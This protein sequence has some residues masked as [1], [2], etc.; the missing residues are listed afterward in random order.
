MVGLPETSISPTI[1]NTDSFSCHLTECLDLAG[2]IIIDTACQRTCC[3]MKWLKLHDQLL[4][5]R[6]LS[7]KKL[8]VSDH[9]QFGAGGV[10]IAKQ[11]A[12]IPVGLQ[13]TKQQGLLFGAGVLQL[14]LPLLASNTL[15]D[16]LGS[17]INLVEMK[18]HATKLGIDIPIERKHNHLV[19]NILNFPSNVHLNSC[20]QQL[21]DSAVWESPHPEFIAVPGVILDQKSTVQ[22]SIQSSSDANSRTSPTASGMAP[23]LEDD[24]DQVD[25]TANQVPSTDVKDGEIQASTKTVAFADGGLG[26]SSK[27]TRDCSETPDPSKGVH[28]PDSS[29]VRKPIWPVCSVQSMRSEVPVERRSTRLGALSAKV[30]AI[31]CLAAAIFGNHGATSDRGRDSTEDQGQEFGQ[32]FSGILTNFADSS[33]G[34]EAR[35]VHPL[36][37]GGDHP[38]AKCNEPL[39]R[40]GAGEHPRSRSIPTGLGRSGSR[41]LLPIQSPGVRLGHVE[42]QWEFQDGMLVRHHRMPRTTLFLPDR[43]QCPIQI[44]RLLPICNAKMWFENSAHQQLQYNW[45]ELQETNYEETMPPWT[46]CTVFKISKT[47][48][49]SGSNYATRRKLRGRLLQT[50]HVFAAEASIMETRTP[51]LRT[52]VDI[53]ETFAGQGNI[54]RRCVQFGLKSLAPIDYE[55]GWDLYRKE[56]QRHVDRAL[57]QFKPLLLVQGLDCK[58][59]CLLQDNVNYIHRLE[60]LWQRRARARPLVKRAAGWCAKQSRENRYW[61]IENPLTSRLWQEEC[62][63]QI[64]Q[65]PNVETAVCHGGAYGMTNSKHQLVKKSFRFMGNCEPILRRLRKKLD[66]ELLKQCVPIEGSETTATQV[67]PPEMVK[68]IILGARELAKQHDPDR[69]VPQRFVSYAVEVDRSDQTWRPIL[70]EAMDVFGL[71]NQ[72]T[73]VLTRGDKLAGTIM[74]MIPS[75][76]IERIQLSLQPLTHRFLTHIPHTHR[77]WVLWFNDDS[78]DVGLEDLG[79]LRYPRSRFIKPVRLA[80]FVFGFARDEQQTGAAGHDQE[81]Q[82][83]ELP[84]DPALLQGRATSDGMSFPGLEKI[85]SEIKRAVKRL[86][87]NMG[88]PH[89]SEL[90]KLLSLNGVRNQAIFTAID[91]LHCDSCARTK[92]LPRPNPAGIPSNQGFMQFGDVVQMDIFYTR[93]LTGKNYTVLGCICESTHLHQAG[94]IPDRTPQSVLECLDTMWFKPY[95]YPLQIKTDCDGAFQGAFID[96]A[97]ENG[98]H[99]DYASPENHAEIGLVERHNSTLRSI[100]ERIVDCRGVTDDFNMKIAI[101]AALFGKNAC[102][103]TH[104]RPPFIAALGRIPRFGTDLLSDP[105]A[106]V[107]GSTAAEAQRTADLM[108]AEAQKQIAVMAID[109]SVRRALLKKTEAQ[110]ALDVEPGGIVAYWRWTARSHK[111]RGGFKLGRLLGRDPD[112]KSIWVQSGGSSIKVA[113]HQ[114]RQALGF[115]QWMP[116]KEDLQSL[117]DAATNLQQGEVKDHSLPAPPQNLEPIFSG[118]ELAAANDPYLPLVVPTDLEEASRG[119]KR[120]EPDSSPQPEPSLPPQINQQQQ[121]QIQQNIN[122]EVQSP[123]HRTINIQQSNFGIPETL[124]PVRTPL[125]RTRSRTPSRSTGRPALEPVPEL[126]DALPEV[127]LTPE[128]SDGNAQHAEETAL[129]SNVEQPLQQDSGSLSRDRALLT[130]RERSGSLSELR[131]LHTAE[132]HNSQSRSQ[133]FAE[134]SGQTVPVVDLTDETVGDMVPQTPP[135]D[136]TPERLTPAK[137]GF[138]V[139][140]NNLVWSEDGIQQQDDFYDGSEEIKMP[141]ACYP[142]HQVYKTSQDY[143]GDGQSDDS[144]IEFTDMRVGNAKPTGHHMSRIERKAMD[145]ELPVHEI[146]ARGG[147]YLEAFVEAARQEEAS[148]MAW[149]SV[150]PLTDKEAQEVMN[151]P[152]LRKRIIP[153]RSAYRDKN[154]GVGDLRA[155]AR[156]VIVGCL[157]PDIYVLNRQCSTPSRQAEYV[158]L[159]FFAAGANGVLLNTPDRWTLWSGDVKTAFLQGRPEKR[160]MPIFMRPP[161]DP[162]SKQAG[163]FG[164]RLYLIEGNVYGIASAPRTW[165]LEVIRRL[166]QAGYRQ[167][168]LDEMLFCFYDVPENEDQAR[169]LSICLVYVDDFLLVHS[170]KYN[171]SHLTSLFTCM[172]FTDG[173]QGRSAGRV[174]GQND[175]IVA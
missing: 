97:N 83:E 52:R 115:E 92:P 146:M 89:A 108:R 137:R 19:C 100:L 69:F 94:I 126:R 157:D 134:P 58:D 174:Q 90:K 38:K 44:S 158:L 142:Y 29:S 93:D 136:S 114:L 13:G 175:I 171:R 61:L 57:D 150:K 87:K 50:A 130:P 151:S 31:A 143:D 37:G 156:V 33:L 116:D 154:K 101:T 77:A 86:H 159:S 71:T 105:R 124:Q 46:G 15:L 48:V 140:N 41:K 121:Q 65:L 91:K 132:E 55:T 79:E 169:L 27:T 5:S 122:I 24:V 98:I 30:A 2:Y 118:E 162:I 173:M 119:T 12:Y 106:L 128:L 110:Q 88:H 66:A 153:S 70:Q 68:A 35:D 82:V 6:K 170:E 34:D 152:T 17:V 112:G 167:H 3:G 28:S 135:S 10:Q 26:R 63:Q 51:K 64:S 133:H 104:G 80:I 8:T 18:L 120:R 67:Y 147:K 7:S 60:Q 56:D 113:P 14:D 165:A 84:E 144:D 117:R 149:K 54:S 59:W 85:S 39:H 75:L 9:F 168:T 166:L 161:P 145:K 4:H 138:E 172:G 22:V 21:E 36:H 125:R 129:P 109:S 73:V 23:G 74:E 45:C 43:E 95:G 81:E 1:D 76:L 78:I 16:M 160:E 111:K 127:S 99:V 148:W 141:Y 62:I 131:A 163:T 20:W 123:T 164:A 40:G 49:S 32:I 139:M 96:A 103:W 155:K 102:T 25:D 53:L 107:M 42:D 72:K 47:P 11:R